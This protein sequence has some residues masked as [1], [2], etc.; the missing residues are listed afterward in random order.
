MVHRRAGR[1][2]RDLRSV[3]GPDRRPGLN[4]QG[5]GF[6]VLAA[7]D[8]NRFCVVDTGHG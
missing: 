3:N 5:A 6:V 8:G 2:S 4:P 7:P 1:V